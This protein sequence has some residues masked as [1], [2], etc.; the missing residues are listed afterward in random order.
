MTTSLNCS[1]V[2]YGSLVPTW[3]IHSSAQPSRLTMISF[4]TYIPLSSPLDIFFTP[5]QT[6]YSPALLHGGFCSHQ[7]FSLGSLFSFFCI[8][9]PNRCSTFPVTLLY[10]CWT[11]CFNQTRGSPESPWLTHPSLNP[12]RR[13]TQYL[14]H[15]KAQW[16]YEK[17]LNYS[18]FVRLTEDP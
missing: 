11:W 10:M 4:H 8:P 18:G 17:C 1:K 15:S 2:L 13:L 7:F 3:F 16:I 14:G 6:E 5:A 12:S 9:P